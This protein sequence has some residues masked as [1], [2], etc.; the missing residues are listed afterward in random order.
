MWRAYCTSVSSDVFLLALFFFPFSFLCFL[1]FFR[2]G[3]VW[4]GLVGL[5]LLLLGRDCCRDGVAIA[6]RALG[7]PRQEL[8]A[9]VR[10]R[11]IL[12]PGWRT[13]AHKACCRRCHTA[14]RTNGLETGRGRRWQRRR[15]QWVQSHVEKQIAFL[16]TGEFLRAFE[17][18]S[19]ANRARLG[20]AATF[21]K[22]VK[23]NSSFAALADPNNP[24]AC[25]FNPT[26]N[27]EG[28]LLV[29]ATVQASHA[30]EAITFGFDVCESNGKHATEGV[31]IMC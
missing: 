10:T 30:G 5:A 13:A 20:N 22:V 3:L 16:R 18:N 24:Y 23:S 6:G 2:F 29:E 11:R 31:R 26:G 21:E 1:S 7:P 12:R 28:M 27:K 14:K 25:A 9:L 4:F 15:R 8:G 17:L 19:T